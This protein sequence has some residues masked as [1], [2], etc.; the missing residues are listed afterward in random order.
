[1][2]DCSGKVR[3]YFCPPLF[4]E[5]EHCAVQGS[6][7]LLLEERS[8]K[9]QNIVVYTVSSCCNIVRLSDRKKINGLDLK[10]ALASASVTKS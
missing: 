5:L 10:A 4:T 8:T 3:K 9:V 7:F 6:R 1:M 2:L